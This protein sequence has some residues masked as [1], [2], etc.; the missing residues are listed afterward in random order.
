MNP[1]RDYREVNNVKMKPVKGEGIFQCFHD[2]E[3]KCDGICVRFNSDMGNYEYCEKLVIYDTLNTGV[4][5]KAL[6]GGL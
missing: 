6:K 2:D 3:P 5:A 1:N 4:H